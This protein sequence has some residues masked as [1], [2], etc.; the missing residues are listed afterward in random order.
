MTLTRKCDKGM[1]Y[2]K[3]Y[4]RKR[5][6]VAGH[7]IRSQKRTNESSQNKMRQNL[8]RI[9]KQLR[10][11]RIVS[12]TYKVSCPKGK[13][14]RKAYIRYSKKGERIFVKEGCI[15][16]IR[17]PRKSLRAGPGIGPLR[18][19]DLAK[20][21]YVH[22]ASMTTT[23]RHTALKK[24]IKEYGSLTVWRKLNA[25][26]VYTRS[27]IPSNSRIFKEDMDWIRTT[28]GIKAF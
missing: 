1:R 10:D 23:A 11:V 12:R 2:R 27:T 16:N 25:V 7:C 15:S 17:A 4:M 26:Y 19:G 14:L 5:T 24:A 13:I 6:R 18:K 21:G 20:H 3:S 9:S 28:F 22:V 8:A